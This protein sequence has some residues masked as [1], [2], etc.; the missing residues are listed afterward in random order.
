MLCCYIDRYYAMRICYIALFICVTRLSVIYTYMCT[1]I[2]IYIY[3]YIYTHIYICI[4]VY[5]ITCLCVY[6]SL[7]LYIYI[8]I[9]IHV[10]I[11]HVWQPCSILKA[12]GHIVQQCA[13]YLRPFRWLARRLFESGRN[14][15]AREPDKGF[16][17]RRIFH[18]I[19]DLSPYMGSPFIRLCPL[20]RDSPYKGFAFVR[21]FPAEGISP[22]TIEKTNTK[23][24][25]KILG[26]MG[27]QNHRENNKRKH[28]LER[29]P[30]A[31]PTTIFCC[32]SGNSFL[33][34][35]ESNTTSTTT[36]TTNNNNNHIIIIIIK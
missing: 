10:C 29:T 3:T 7:S 13:V 23:Q 24:N 35:R 26:P 32:L 11:I 31:Q 17:L 1:C 12:L 15:Q 36:T 6:L 30:A 16:P 33:T 27:S 14:A 21:D 18:L 20:I 22:Y 5:I 34:C 4:Y 28:A 19:R 25:N 9:Y 8:Y 2:Y